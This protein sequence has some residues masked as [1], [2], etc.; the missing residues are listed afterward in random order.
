MLGARARRLCAAALFL[1][2]LIVVGYGGA[3][4]LPRLGRLSPR[5]RLTG[6][7]LGLFNGAAIVAMLLRNWQYSQG[8]PPAR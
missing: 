8:A 3:V 7:G 5:A 2:P 1:L 4:L 6:A